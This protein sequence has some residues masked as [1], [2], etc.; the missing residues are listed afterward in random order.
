MSEHYK[1]EGAISEGERKFELYRRTISLFLGPVVFFIILFT[2]LPFL[3][4]EAHRL[5]AVLGLVLI[6]WVGEAIPIPV[7]ALLGAILNILLGVASAKNVFSPF[8]DPIV[9]L[10]IGS[11]II[12]EAVTLHNLDKRF[13][14]AIFSHRRARYTH[15]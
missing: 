12:A 2:P 5:S 1:I 15:R 14:L 11:F 4:A 6:Y 3:S 7:T 9:F 13:A 10:F 8:A